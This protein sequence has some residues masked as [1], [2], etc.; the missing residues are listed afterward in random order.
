MSHIMATVKTPYLIP[1]RGQIS[2]A[3]TGSRAN[4]KDAKAGLLQTQESNEEEEE[5]EC[6]LVAEY[7]IDQNTRNVS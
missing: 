2:V 1:F 5:E 3:E 7:A 6:T 4:S